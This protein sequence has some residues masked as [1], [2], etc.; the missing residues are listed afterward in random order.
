MT[1]RIFFKSDC[2]DAQTVNHMDSECESWEV[3]GNLLILHVPKESKEGPK[4]YPL[5]NIHSFRQV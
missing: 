4:H 2:S 1:I 3:T 5:I